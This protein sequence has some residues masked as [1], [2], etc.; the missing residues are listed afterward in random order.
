VILLA[1]CQSIFGVNQ[2]D[3]AVLESI[4]AAIPALQQLPDAPWT[5]NFT[6]NACL[7]TG[8][9]CTSD[10]RVYSIDLRRQGLQGTMPDS[11]CSL[12]NITELYISNNSLSSA[13]PTQ[14][15]RVHFSN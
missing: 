1:A 15:D 9:A 13:Y 6:A 11:I 5:Q 8:I 10:G 12:P 7:W 4:A 3:L 14:T 2:N